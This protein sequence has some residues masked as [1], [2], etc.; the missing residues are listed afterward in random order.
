MNTSSG[1]SIIA[2]GISKN[3]K[4]HVYSYTHSVICCCKKEKEVRSEYFLFKVFC[5]FLQTA[6]QKNALMIIIVSHCFALDN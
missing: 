5:S 2:C 4:T 3:E 1:A 6:C